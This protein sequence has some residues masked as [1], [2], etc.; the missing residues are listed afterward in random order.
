MKRCFVAAVLCAV[1]AVTFAQPAFSI[2]IGDMLN[3]GGDAKPVTPPQEMPALPK[4]EPVKAAIEEV[5][6]PTLP[7]SLPCKPEWLFGLWELQHVYESP[8]GTETEAYKINPV[9]YVAFQKDSRF[10][11][12]NAGRTESKPEDVLKLMTGHSGALLQYLLQD[13]GMLYLYQDSVATDTEVCFV[14][15]ETK[16]PYAAGNL[17]LMPPKGQING[18][19][20]KLYKK[21]WPP[22][23]QPQNRQPQ[24]TPAV[25]PT[26]R[27]TFRYNV[28]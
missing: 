8:L 10:Y 20:I 11:R 26:I 21:V 6:I 19:L 1:I 24:P 28:R 17:L 13:A 12:F 9:Q 23:P 2:D 4:P 27:S 15:A 3:P 7:P 5:A 25:R 22:K 14:V 18:R 16:P